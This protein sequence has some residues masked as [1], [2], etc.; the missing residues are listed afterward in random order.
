MIAPPPPNNLVQHLGRPVCDNRGIA[1][2]INGIGLNAAEESLELVEPYFEPTK[3]QFTKEF[4]PILDQA[5]RVYG[6]KWTEMYHAYAAFKP[7]T[8]RKVKDRIRIIAEGKKRKNKRLVEA[9]EKPLD[10]GLYAFLK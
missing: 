1:A 8:P 10:L 6:S 4:D 3:P 7:F 9:G 2:K 5:F